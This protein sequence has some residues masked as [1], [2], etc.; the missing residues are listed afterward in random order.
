MCKKISKD[1]GFTLIE[2]MVV[3][4]ISAILSVIAVPNMI[5]WR[6]NATLKGNVLNL[7]GY[8]EM[9]KLKAI[10]ENAKVAVVF[11]VV[12]NGYSVFVDNGAGSN[13]NNWIHDEDE[14]LLG[15][16]KSPAGITLSTTRKNNKLRFNSR[17]RCAGI[18]I[19]SANINGKQMDVIVSIVGRIRIS[20]IY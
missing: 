18:T 1:T 14:Q 16:I 4:A 20:S 5:G 9:A 13:A 7:T 15:N 3:I 12:D 8:M 6:N 11:D 2:L 17:G 10:K 19:T